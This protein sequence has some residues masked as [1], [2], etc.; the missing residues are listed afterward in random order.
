MTSKTKK[1]MSPLAPLAVLAA[2][3][4][5]CATA[6]HSTPSWSAETMT[7]EA[8]QEL[9]LEELMRAINDGACAFDVLPAAGPAQ[10]ADRGTTGEQNDDRNDPPGGGG[11]GRPSDDGDDGGPTCGEGEN[12]AAN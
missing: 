5:S 10:V 1:L 9:P 11:G 12:T 4:A 7:T 6:L 8:C 2:L 3:A